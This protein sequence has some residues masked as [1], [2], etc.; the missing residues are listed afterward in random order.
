MRETASITHERHTY[1]YIGH[2]PAPAFSPSPSPKIRVKSGKFILKFFLFYK[3]GGNFAIWKLCL[4]R[5][6][7]APSAFR[8][9]RMMGTAA[10]T[11][12]IYKSFNM[13]KQFMKPEV[14]QTMEVLL[15]ENLL[16][17]SQITEMESSVDSMGQERKEEAFTASDNLWY[18]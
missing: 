3:K 1:N 10:E 6:R 11:E 8:I 5:S 12:Y 16:G 14:L 9:T 17:D 7:L 13:K 15:E 18:D 2:F 4:I